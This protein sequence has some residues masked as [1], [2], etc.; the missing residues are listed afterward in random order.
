MSSYVYIVGRLYRW[1]SEV[2]FD[3]W[4]DSSIQ[5]IDWSSKYYPVCFSI[6][7]DMIKQKK[8]GMYEA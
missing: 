3:S 6:I 1:T 5:Q 4:E 2:I 8:E 7:V